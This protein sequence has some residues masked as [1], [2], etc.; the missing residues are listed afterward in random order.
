MDWTG[1]GE[2]IDTES[3]VL[4]WRQV[5][6]DIA[7]AVVSGELVSGERLPNEFALAEV[8]GVARVT[9]RRAMEELKSRGLVRVQQ[10][11]GTFV[12]RTANNPPAE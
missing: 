5:A 3:S 1:R 6:D 12:T 10:G 4:L 11:R 9:I 2:H 8:Y 7:A